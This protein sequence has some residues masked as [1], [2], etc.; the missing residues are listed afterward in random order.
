[1]GRNEASHSLLP[2]DCEFFCPS[3][4][5]GVADTPELTPQ[6]VGSRVQESSQAPVLNGG[7]QGDMALCDSGLCRQEF[8]QDQRPWLPL[9]SESSPTRSM[10]PPSEDAGETESCPS[11]LK[12]EQPGG[13]HNPKPYHVQTGFFNQEV[14]SQLGTACQT[15]PHCQGSRMHTRGHSFWLGPKG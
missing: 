12:A 11:K 13:W 4:V 10:S 7:P 3:V 1:M 5:I 15:L 2:A 6:R 9:S 14:G 8:S